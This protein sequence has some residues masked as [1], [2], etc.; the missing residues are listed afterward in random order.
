MAGQDGYTDTRRLADLEGELAE[1]E[2]QIEELERD[3]R[4]LLD[5]VRG[6]LYPRI[7]SWGEKVVE[8]ETE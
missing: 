6:K 3:I 4:A 2:R 7:W 1:I 5:E 8:V